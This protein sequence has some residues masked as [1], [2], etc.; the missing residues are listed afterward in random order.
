M[1]GGWMIGYVQGL[2]SIVEAVANII[3]EV[4][5]TIPNLGV[6]VASAVAGYV[7]H[8]VNPI[9][10]SYWEFGILLAIGGFI[11]IARGDRDRNSD[12]EKSLEEQPLPTTRQE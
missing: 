3:F 2:Q 5:A 9:Y 7:A 6:I 8:I 4:A 10:G 11:L 12:Q 1:L